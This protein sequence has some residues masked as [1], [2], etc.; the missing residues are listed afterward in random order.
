MPV[1]SLYEFEQ[2]HPEKAGWF[3]ASHAPLDAWF[4]LHIPDM[5]ETR[6]LLV[7]VRPDEEMLLD[8]FAL[9][10]DKTIVALLDRVPGREIRR[11]GPLRA[12]YVSW[13]DADLRDADPRRHED[14]EILITVNMDFHT[15]FEWCADAGGT[16]VYTVFFYLDETGELHG[17]V[18][19]GSFLLTGGY[20]FCTEA[21]FRGLDERLPRGI[22]RL[23]ELV[24][25][26]LARFGRGRTFSRLYILPGRGERRGR[27]RWGSADRQV[28]LGLLPGE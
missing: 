16:I 14:W 24:D 6:S 5:R 21:I 28:C 20:P 13:G 7:R 27:R 10:N 17:E 15:S 4:P 2:G 11:F 12:S 8:L 23:Q 19:G 22:P 1:V 18:E 9:F 26:A 25:G 3:R